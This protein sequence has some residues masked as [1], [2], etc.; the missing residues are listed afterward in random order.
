[1]IYLLKSL[2]SVVKPIVPDQDFVEH[3]VNI[4][5]VIVRKNTIPFIAI[6]LLVIW[7]VQSDSKCHLLAEVEVVAV[8]D[9]VTAV[10]DAVV[11]MDEV[12]IQMV[13]M[14]MEVESEDAITMIIMNQKTNRR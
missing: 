8:E 13:V 1:M 12:V 10:V 11:V 3:P 5:I 9:V 2:H 6:W 14:E 7:F 4:L